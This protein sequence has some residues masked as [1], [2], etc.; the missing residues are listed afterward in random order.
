MTNPTVGQGYIPLK[1]FGRPKNIK[2]VALVKV[3]DVLQNDLQVNPE[4]TDYRWHANIE[5]WPDSKEER[6]AIAQE[7]ARIA[8]FE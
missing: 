4:E 2:V 1:L 5:G 8:I 6:K 3:N 7:L